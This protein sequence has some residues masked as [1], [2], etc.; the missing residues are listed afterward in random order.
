MGK[1]KMSLKLQPWIDARKR[2]NLAHAHIQV[3]RELGMN[4]KKLGGLANHKQE[5]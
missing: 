3:A 2:S 5:P 1:S 4:S